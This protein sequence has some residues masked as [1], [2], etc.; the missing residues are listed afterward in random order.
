MPYTTVREAMAHLNERWPKARVTGSL[1]YVLSDG[2]PED[3]THVHV[4]FD[5]GTPT[6]VEGPLENP[7]AIVNMTAANFIGMANGTY[8]VP[9]GWMN[10][11]FRVSGPN[12]TLVRSLHLSRIRG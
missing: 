5:A 12:T 10:G 2:L 6:I 8:I 11:S 7:D 4:L 9:L 3:V 1:L